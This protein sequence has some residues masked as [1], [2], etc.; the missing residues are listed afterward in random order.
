[1]D[2]LME[3]DME[4]TVVVMG[5]GWV[6]EGWEEWEWEGGTVVKWECRVRMYVRELLPPSPFPT[7]FV[8]LSRDQLAH[9]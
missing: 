1:M 7:L 6:W 9:L 2:R 5:V 3:V 8:S 4:G